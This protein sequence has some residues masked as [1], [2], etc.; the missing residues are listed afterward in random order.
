MIDDDVVVS[1][2]AEQ[3]YV[4]IDHY[5]P[6]PTI[7]ALAEVARAKLLNQEMAHARTGKQAEMRQHIR[8]D[9]ICWL[10]ED[11]SDIATQ[12]YFAHMQHIKQL[13]NQQLYMGLASLETHLAIYPVGAVYQK[14]LDQFSADGSAQLNTRKISSILYLNEGW[15]P[16]HGGELRLYLD[17]Q[18]W[19]D[20]LPTGG[21]LVL[22]L[23]ADFWHEVR[24]ATRA[25]IS[26][27]GWF[28][29]RELQL[30]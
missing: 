5:L 18:K 28:R 17:N 6:A 11:S 9:Q 19:I 4:I 14:H 7:A 20:I 3:G 8:G 12:Q 26:L 16:V 22:F 21:R 2:L 10:D 25:R 1:T 24:P 27:T 13:I 15:L 29:T 30:L 23:S